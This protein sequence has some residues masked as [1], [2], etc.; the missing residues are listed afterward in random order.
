MKLKNL[1]SKKKIMLSSLFALF[2]VAIIGF[3]NSYQV[4]AEDDVHQYALGCIPDSEDVLEDLYIYKDLPKAA[5]EKLPDY[6]DLES[7][8]P[9]PGNQGSQGSCTAWAVAYAAKS[10]QE[11][12][13][14]F[15]GN[16][17]L[18]HKNRIQSCIFV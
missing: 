9:S 14:T 4:K 18:E 10:Y 2:T 3:S 8:M 12:R 6:V 11:N 15:M 5:D 13:G 7:K 17:R 16:K 1:K